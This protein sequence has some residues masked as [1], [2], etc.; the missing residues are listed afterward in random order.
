MKLELAEAGP[1]AVEESEGMALP[2]GYALS[3]NYPN[4]F[5]P[6]TTISYDVEK[7]GAV[8]L[9]VYALTGQFVRTLMD[10]GRAAGRYSVMRN[11]S[12]LPRRRC[13]VG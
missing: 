4:P 10:G 11:A 3:Q 7:T 12:P 8:Q 2:S 9:S 13:Q 5:N 1:T 6:E